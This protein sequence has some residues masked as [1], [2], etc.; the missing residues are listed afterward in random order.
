MIRPSLR[1]GDLVVLLS[2]AGPV[3]DDGRLE[4]ARTTVE[5]LGLRTR[6]APNAMARSGFLAGSDEQRLADLND[7]LRDPEVR[8]IFALR[9][10]Y[11]TMRLLPGVDYDA[12]ARDPKVVLGYSDLTALLNTMTARAG[13][14]TL[15]GPVATSG[16]WS[17]R[18][19]DWLRPMLFGT[20]DAL[21]HTEDDALVIRN[22]SATG[23]IAGG[24]LS[25]VSSLVGTPYA[26]DFRDAIVVLEEI[27]EA[28]Y[29]VDRM[30]T[31]MRLA[32][33]FDGARAVLVGRCVG[34]DVDDD[35]IYGDVKLLDVLRERLGDLGIPVLAE[36]P[37]GHMDEQW[38]LP[39]GSQATLNTDRRALSINFI[40]PPVNRP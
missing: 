18:V 22:G 17:G 16:A 8:G 9:G 33:V 40:E 13:V 6:V 21:T 3:P 25:L 26:I 35:H 11:G 20:D 12:L 32:N 36:V 1:E 4:N 37:V 23:R 34:C 14:I 5:A 30:L 39:I 27:D 38:T 31:Q 29:R 24:N 10:G 28:P 7:A 15:H 19:I 2:P